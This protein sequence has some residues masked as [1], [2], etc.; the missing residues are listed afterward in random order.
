MREKFAPGSLD[1]GWSLFNLARVAEDRG[2]RQTAEELHVRALG[3][4]RELAPGS[5]A[6]AFTLYRLG[7]LNREASRPGEA[8]RYFG[9]AIQ[10][11]ESQVGRLGG[12]EETR[13]GF[14][15]ERAAYYR[16]Y[17]EVLIELEE[18]SRAFEVLERSR[19]RSLLTM[20][21]ERDLSFT[22]D[23]PP[24]LERERKRIAADYDRT[25]AAM[26]RLDPVKNSADID[27]LQ[28]RLGGLRDAREAI[29]QKVRQ[30]SPRFAA[31]QYPQTLDVAR[32]RQHL[33][34]GTLLLSYSVGKH[35]TIL[36]VVQPLQRVVATA[37][38][39]SVFTLP[40]GAEALRDQVIAFRNVIQRQSGSGREGIVALEA[41]GKELFDALVKPAQHL[42]A[43]ATRVV[44]LPD[45]PLHT[46]P[47]GALVLSQSETAR[48]KT[49]RAISSSG[50]RSTV[51]SR[52]PY[53]RN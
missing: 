12:A 18:P 34:P 22:S 17:S 32:T 9:L 42:I 27:G 43:G 52:R 1:V 21:A 10:A 2:D 6:E 24:E 30:A 26:V 45:G 4:F 20:L 15:A 23:V 7:V 3:L 25:Q 44:I 31:L 19:A 33:D 38:G 39:F 47:F 40:I 11:L 13:S 53:T 50:S 51:S 36:F 41:Q 49:R 35:K 37:P 29:A 16:E 14:A 28:V 5:A 48:A 46:L 8:A